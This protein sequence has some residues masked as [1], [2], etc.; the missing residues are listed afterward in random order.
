[1]ARPASTS[2]CCGASWGSSRS[3]LLAAEV[4]READDDAPLVAVEVLGAREV[5]GNV[6]RAAGDLDR[7]RTNL[8]MK[9]ERLGLAWE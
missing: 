5:G 3:A 8:H 7:E 6:R 2:G 9:I 4:E 1:M